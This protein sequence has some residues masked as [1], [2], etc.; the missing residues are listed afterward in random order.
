MKKC[1]GGK[2]QKKNYCQGRSQAVWY[3]K[4]KLLVIGK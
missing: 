4:Q 1:F 2:Q 3:E